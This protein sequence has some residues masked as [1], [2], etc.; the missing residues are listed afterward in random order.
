MH[1]NSSCLQLCT[2]YIRN[3]LLIPL[4]PR[5]FVLLSHLHSYQNLNLEQSEGLIISPHITYWSVIHLLLR[6]KNMVFYPWG[7]VYSKGEY[8]CFSPG[9]QPLDL[10]SD[11]VMINRAFTEVGKL[12][13]T[14]PY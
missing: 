5:G 4:F 8:F 6:A 2:I 10:S 12:K 13:P 7:S 9:V 3:A 1:Q 14:M 11:G